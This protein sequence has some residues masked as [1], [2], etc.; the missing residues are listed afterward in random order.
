MIA[1]WLF[2]AAAVAV[3]LWWNR[4]A[5]PAAPLPPL[6]PIPKPAPLP[7]VTAPAAPPSVSPLLLGA[8]LAPWGLL[9]WS[10]FA[11]HERSP[12]PPAPAPSPTGDVLDLRGKFTGATAAEDA[13]IVGVLLG[14]CRDYLRHDLVADID[15]DGKPDGPRLTTG[16]K[17]AELRTIARDY[18]TQGVRLADRQPLALDAIAAYFDR[19]IGVDGG[20]LS[21]ATRDR[22]IA[23]LDAAS[24]AALAAAGR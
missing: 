11:N 21:D 18:R 13:A 24:K 8:I 4:S 5:A 6:S 15:H 20:P 12:A 23:G 16:Q 1:P 22:W 2:A 19:A 17:V 9:A 10:Q 7:P 3:V 14:A